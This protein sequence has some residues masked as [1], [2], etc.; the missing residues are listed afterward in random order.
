MLCLGIESSCDETALALVRDGKLLGQTLNS[1]VDVHALFG[2]VVPELASREHGR[3]I[4]PL[5]DLLLANCGVQAAELGAVAVARGPGLLGSLLVGVA[6][7][8]GLALSLGLPIIGVNHLHAHILTAGLEHSIQFPALALLVSGGHTH[9]YLVESAVKF[10]L[11]GRSIDDAAGEAL[12]KFGKMVGLPYPA[13][14]HI[15]LFGATG[16]ADKKLFPSP[17]LDNDNL[18][19]SFSGLKTAALNYLQKHP[20]LRFQNKPDEK[21][22]FSPVLPEGGTGTELADLCASYTHTV[23]FTLVEKMERAMH[24]IGI[25]SIGSVIMA[26]GVAANSV[27]REYMLSLCGKHNIS[28]LVPSPALCTDNAAMIAYSGE[29][30]LHEGYRHDLD[31]AAIPRG[32][33]VPDDY[34]NFLS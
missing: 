18:D 24:K 34:R 1:Q 16:K 8:K 9:I 14:R 29:L 10:T 21:S 25:K 32:Q 12:D 33:Q 7:A 20:H 5:F 4:G 11:L 19:F 17:Y 23:A 22:V 13:G 30:L 31:F 3:S 26:G 15:D 27:V 28:L 6:F 2:G